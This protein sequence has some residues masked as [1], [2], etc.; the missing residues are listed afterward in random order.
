MTPEEMAASNDAKRREAERRGETFQ[1]EPVQV[2]LDNEEK[3]R[4]TIGNC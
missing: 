2:H 4:K 3:I 1:E